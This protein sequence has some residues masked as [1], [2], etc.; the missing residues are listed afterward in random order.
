MLLLSISDMPNLAAMSGGVELQIILYRRANL[1]YFGRSAGP[2]TLRID[3]RVISLQQTP[4]DRVQQDPNCIPA[5]HGQLELVLLSCNHAPHC[6]TL[7]CVFG[8]VKSGTDFGH[9]NESR[10]RGM[11][12]IKEL[13]LLYYVKSSLEILEMVRTIFRRTAA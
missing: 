7:A 8:M 6:G 1:K 10:I 5:L 11:W 12:K 9:H 2:T 3:W 13:D 4:T